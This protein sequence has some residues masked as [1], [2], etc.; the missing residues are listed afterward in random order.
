MI[1]QE[2][3]PILVLKVR[4]DPKGLQKT[5]QA[6]VQEVQNLQGDLTLTPRIVPAIA[7]EL[8]GKLKS[9]TL[10]DNFREVK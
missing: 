10:I 6:F 3:V 9:M 1:L 2:R 8:A 5:L 4:D 7:G